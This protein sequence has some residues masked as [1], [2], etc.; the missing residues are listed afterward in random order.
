MLPDTNNENITSSYENDGVSYQE[1]VYTV[2]KQKS[3]IM[4]IAGLVL[5]LTLFYTSLQKPVY[6]STGLIMIDDPTT[7]NMF[8]MSTFRGEKK[9]LSNEIQILSSRTI[10][11]KTIEKLNSA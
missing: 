3:M 10:S 7:M 8:D 6:S 1:I 11:E 4:L 2:K 9:Y 5:M